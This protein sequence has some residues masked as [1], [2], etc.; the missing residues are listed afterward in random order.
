VGFE[1]PPDAAY[2]GEVAIEVEADALHVV[3]AATARSG[4][5]TRCVRR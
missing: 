4:R 1:L 5:M 2:A 3:C